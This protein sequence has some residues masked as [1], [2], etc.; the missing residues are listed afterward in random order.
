MINKSD[1]SI[2]GIEIGQDKPPFFIADIAANHDGELGRAVELIHLAAESGA[3]AAKFQHFS[4]KTLVSDV[5]FRSLGGKYSHQA[6]WTKSV[7]E[8][9]K[10]ASINLEW[11]ERLAEAS[12][13]AGIS[14]MS[15]PYSL[16]LA[17]HIDPYVEA[18][19]IGS[20]DINHLELISHVTRTGKP[21]MIATGAASLSDVRR[22]VESTGSN[23]QGVL[24]QCNTNYTAS[25]ENF[26]H[27]NLRVISTFSKEFP[28][29]VLGLSDHTLGHATVLG[30]LAL[31]ARVF[32][33]HFTDDTSR[34]GPDH[35]FSM[36]P[37]TWRTM[38]EASNE[39]YLSLGDGVKRVQDNERDTVVLQ[40]RCLRIASD[41]PVGTSIEREHLEALRPAPPSS[42]PPSEISK[43]LGKVTKRDMPSGSHI[44]W[45]DLTN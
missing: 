5:G 14:F 42:I 1:F 35:G 29:L 18:Y 9:Y 2:N 6:S 28:N 25:S 22:A 26:H 20:G 16:E 3:H 27:I 15:T 17:N 37:S 33:K 36:T 45:A 24:M 8:V 4:A 12:R 40:R 23:A 10:D 38:V 30:G 44:T 21:W 19:K 13:E 43:V 34:S 39:L 32:E 7:Y 11:T 31:G 41:L